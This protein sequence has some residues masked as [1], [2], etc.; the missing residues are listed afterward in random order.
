MPPETAIPCENLWF[1]EKVDREE[2][3][4]RSPTGKIYRAQCVSGR[5]D[6]ELS[7]LFLE[8]EKKP[9]TPGALTEK[10]QPSLYWIKPKRWFTFHLDKTRLGAA[11][12]PSGFHGFVVTTPAGHNVEMFFVNETAP[13][14]LAEHL[15]L[16][17]EDP[18]TV[19][20]QEPAQP[21]ENDHA[22]GQLAHVAVS[23]GSAPGLGSGDGQADQGLQEHGGLGQAGG[24][25]VAAEEGVR[26]V[27]PT[28]PGADRRA[29]LKPSAPLVESFLKRRSRSAPEVRP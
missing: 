2:A 22:E 18:A 3:L 12:S 26:K 20:T 19:G 24:E 1:L 17:F 9:L 28:P 14:D 27:V 4:F 10:A 5:F 25:R 29:R 16:L 6:Y 21:E 7:W 11:F 23:E 13:R 15:R 8:L